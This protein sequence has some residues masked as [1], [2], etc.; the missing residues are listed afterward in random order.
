M[1]RSVT[2]TIEG[3][4]LV[5]IT[6]IIGLVTVYIP[7]VGMFAEFFFTLPLAVLTVR[8]GV[9]K[10][11]SAMF[12]AL[13]LLSILISPLLALRLILG[14]GICGVAFGW[15]VKKNFG[16]VKIFLVTLTVASA[17]QILLLLL[18][19]VIMNVNFIEMQIQILRD[20]FDDSFTMYESMGVDKAQIE[21]S[22]GQVE[23][24]LQTLA[25]MIPTLVL[26]SALINSVA[27][28]FTSQWI[29]PKLQL[30]LPT[31]PPFAEW[32]FPATFLYLAAFGALGMYWGVTRG[33]TQIQ[34]L[35]LNVLF[36]SMIIGLVQ[37]LA[38]LSALFD[39]WNVSKFVRRFLY[40]IIFLNMFFLQLVAITGLVDMLFDY[41]KK[42]FDRK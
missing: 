4:L 13:I 26:L 37:G 2:P 14:C 35:S 38:L 39:K 36:I 42:I 41:R 7:I 12:V 22:K 1:R 11:F 3:G 30:K 27:I 10:G 24:L 34:E 33:W 31:F 9:G 32:K 40:V 15:G 28:W 29:F 5:A 6:V 16:A 17:A 23:P 25:M 19:M 8:Q 20:A 18:L 21:E